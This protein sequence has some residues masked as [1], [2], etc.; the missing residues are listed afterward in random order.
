[1]RLVGQ[2]ILKLYNTNLTKHKDPV[3]NISESALTDSLRCGRLAS[4]AEELRGG[5][6]KL[7]FKDK[8][9]L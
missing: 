6:L 9:A 3:E 2:N 5:E 1:M 7:S 4:D 8:L